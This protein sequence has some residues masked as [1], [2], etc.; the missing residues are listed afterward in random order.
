MGEGGRFDYYYHF[1]AFKAVFASLCNL[2][3]N[4]PMCC[5]SFFVLGVLFVRAALEAYGGSHV[6]G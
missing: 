6:R 1:L 3:L 4:C 2:R 5:I